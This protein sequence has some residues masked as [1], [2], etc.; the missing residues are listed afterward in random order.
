MAFLREQFQ[1][2]PEFLPLTYW[3][4]N[5]GGIWHEMIGSPRYATHPRDHAHLTTNISML[6]SQVSCPHPSWRF[7]AIQSARDAGIDLISPR[8]N[9]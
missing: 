3:R 6:L 2:S 9:F 8:I 4:D 7:V 1:S 5:S